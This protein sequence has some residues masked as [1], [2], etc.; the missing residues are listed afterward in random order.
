MLLEVNDL[1]SGYGFLQVLWGISF[2]IE[3]GEFVA[4][5]GPNGAGKSTA[6]KTVS[7]LLPPKNGTISFNGN[8]INKLDCSDNCKNGLSY[9][10]EELNLFTGMTVL[11]NLEMGAQTLK[12]PEKIQKESILYF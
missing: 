3:K 1:E 4:L 2:Q 8:V 5:I 10:S 9:I 12:S 6:L 11:E 7:G